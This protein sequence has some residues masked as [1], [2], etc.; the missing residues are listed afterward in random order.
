[1]TIAAAEDSAVAVNAPEAVWK[2]QGARASGFAQ[3]VLLFSFANVLAL[4]C[5]GVLTFLLPRLLPMESYG[6]YRLFVLYGGFA[7]VL[8][9]GLLDGA[10]TRWAARPGRMKP[11]MLSSLGFLLAEHAAILVPATAL[12][13]VL[14]H[15][16]PWFFLVIAIASYAVVFNLSTLGQFALQADKVFGLLSAMTVLNPMLLLAS[17]VALHYWHRLTLNALIAAYILSWLMAAVPVWCFLFR[18]FHAGRRRAGHIWQTGSYNIRVGWSVLLALLI[19]NVALSLDRIIVSISFSIR[20]F[21]IYSLAA[22]ALAVVNT[23]ILSVSRVV[24]PYLSDGLSTE[25][26]MRAYWWGEACLVGLWA[27]S[28]TGYFPIHWL[29]TWLL[30]NYLPSLPVLRLLVLG[31]GFTGMIHILQSNYFRS[32]LRLGQLLLGCVFGLVSAAILLMLAR[33]TGQLSMMALAMFG[34]VALWW[35]FNER[36]LK[37]LTGGSS[38][39]LLRTA[40][41]YAGCALWFVFCSSWKNL[42]LAGSSYLLFAL[43]VVLVSYRVVLRTVP[44]I[45]AFPLLS[46]RAEYP[47]SF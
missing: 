12:L 39:N 40:S 23:I 32:A 10:L 11:E 19:T 7:G 41:V 16:K 29:I 3:H 20:E 21:A 34:A 26:Q 9:L 43:V 24:F 31:T 6:Y 47:E 37:P 33:R 4:V 44:I 27:I 14:F 18:K 35:L 46:A 1:M 8:H 15:G 28:L 38:R 17:V 42:V 36:L 22:T 13:A 25:T 2:S 30:P 45:M 5:N